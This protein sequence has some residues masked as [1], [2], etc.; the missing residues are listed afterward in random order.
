MDACVRERVRVCFDLHG[1]H[2][3]A[4]HVPCVQRGNRNTISKE[5][6]GASHFFGGEVA[7]SCSCVL[8]ILRVL[9]A[10]CAHTKTERITNTRMRIKLMH[11][12]LCALRFWLEV[13][14]C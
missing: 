1:Q 11:A 3:A 2:F 12:H 13:Y 10:F 9:N 6:I 8:R 4:S 7:G 5:I 14:K